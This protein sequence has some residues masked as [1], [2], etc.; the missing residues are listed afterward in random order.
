MTDCIRPRVWHLDERIPAGQHPSFIGISCIVRQGSIF[1]GRVLSQ[2]FVLTRGT[3]K[4][5]VVALHGFVN[6]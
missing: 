2:L 3:I 4:E 5:K 1:G 6:S